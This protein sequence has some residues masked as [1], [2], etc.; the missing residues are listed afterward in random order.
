MNV[1]LVDGRF[2]QAVFLP[3][4]IETLPRRTSY[5]GPVSTGGGA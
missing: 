3:P 1:L 5:S 2:D 4:L